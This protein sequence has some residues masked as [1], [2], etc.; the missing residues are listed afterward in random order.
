MKGRVET[1]AACGSCNTEVFSNQ[2]QTVFCGDGC[3]ISL[4]PL[5]GK[6]SHCDNV[7]TCYK[8]IDGLLTDMGLIYKN[9]VFL[10]Q[11]VSEM[12]KEK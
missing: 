3:S 1:V 4:F 2:K 7:N 12:Y 10:L 9:S 8:I 5:N 11:A 6:Y